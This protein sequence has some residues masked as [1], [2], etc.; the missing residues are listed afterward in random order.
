MEELER[1]NKEIESVKTEVEEKQKSLSKFALKREELLRSHITSLSDTNSRQDFLEN[2]LL[3]KGDWHELSKNEESQP[4]KYVLDHKCPAT[5][6]EYDPLL[7]FSAGLLGASK[8]T[9][10]ETYKQRI[11]LLKKSVGE[12]CHKSQESQRPHVSPIR[13]TINLQESDE[14][15][16]VIDIPPIMPTSKKPKP[17]RGFQY[18]NMDDKVPIMSPGESDLQITGTEEEKVD[19]TQLPI[20]VDDDGNKSEPPESLTHSSLDMKSN[21][22][23]NCAKTLL[24]KLVSC[25]GER[26][27]VCVSEESIPRAPFGDK[28]IQNRIHNE[29][30]PHHKKYTRTINDPQNGKN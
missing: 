8:A 29:R 22:N 16:L 11:C 17:L 13:I 1:L 25:G 18:Q 9:R 26:T 2:R 14:D 15:D 5:D 19:K 24:S 12:N 7:N 4:R 10:D 20:Q 27:H 3:P 23:L 21:L 28:E 30:Y 6:L